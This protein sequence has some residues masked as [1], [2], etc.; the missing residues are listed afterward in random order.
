MEL[1]DI[2]PYAGEWVAVAENKVVDHDKDLDILLE[3]MGERDYAF[4][5]SPKGDFHLHMHGIHV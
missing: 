3:R 2:S 5:Y 1:L 4:T